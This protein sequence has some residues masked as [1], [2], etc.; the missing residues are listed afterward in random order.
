MNLFRKLFGPKNEPPKPAPASPPPLP[1]VDPAKDPNMIRVHDAY[2]R[3]LFLTR[4]QWRDSVLLGNIE[5]AWNQPDALYG[6]ILSALNDGF[7]AD[8]VKAAQHLHDI[9]PDPVRG[10]C[11]WGIVLNEEGRLDEAEAVFKA[12]V[13]KHG[14][15]GVVLTNLAKIYAKQG[16][17]AKA[18]AVLWHALELD[19]NQDNGVGWYEVIHRERGGEEAS[20]AAL[21]RIAALPGS[22]RAQLWLARKALENRDLAGALDFYRESLSR[23]DPAPAGALMQIS[24]DL[25]NAGHLVPLLEIVAPRFQATLH[26]LEVGNNLIKAHLDLGQLDAAR[27]ILDQLY[28]LQRPDWKQTLAF[29]DTE[30]AKARVGTS[31]EV[32]PDELKVAMLVIDGPVW[33]KPTSPAAELFP[34]KGAEAV[35]IAFLGGSVEVPT[36]SKRVEHQ[37]SDTRGRLSRSIPLFLT[38][39][40]EFGTTARAQTLVSWITNSPGGFV[41]A[42]A[43]WSDE[44]VTH[45]ARQGETKN[46]FAVCLHLKAGEEPWI[47]QA[48]I[49]RT[50]DG[51]CVGTAE[52]PLTPSQPAEGLV[53]LQRQVLAVLRQEAD[54]VE[55]APPSA[56]AVPGGNDFPYYLLRLEQLLAVR[57]AAMTVRQNGESFLSG[58]REIL[59]GNVQQCIA[60]PGSVSLR[61]LMAQTFWT[62]KVARPDI[63]PE[64][65][66]KAE[67]LQ[68]DHPLPEPA[69]SVVQRILNEAIEGIE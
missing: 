29:W 61:V 45:A 41:L 27:A 31:P 21:Q 1:P 38:E 3:E 60:H 44:Q 6:M 43:P 16:D 9:D 17:D 50:I 10:T 66:E 57:C 22:W 39:Q 54:L 25:G 63:L 5:K 48:R 56:Y 55:Q 51:A 69:Q 58:E 67:M 59:D 53:K 62:M 26:G 28:A 18:E 24:G 23:I 34:T 32:K 33:L 40:V 19:P 36:N 14:E 46:D 37:L 20:R 52:A 30:L 8:I 68:R 47:A 64:F 11:V 35:R 2:G 12:H 15:N 49:I 7:R 4:E 13:A 65:K 42:G